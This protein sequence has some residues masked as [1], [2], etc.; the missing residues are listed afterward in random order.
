VRNWRKVVNDY[1]KS[2]SIQGSG[3][4]PVF[5]LLW[6]SIITDYTYSGVAQQVAQWVV[7]Q[8]ARRVAQQVAQQVLRW[9]TQAI[10]R[11]AQWLGRVGLFFKLVYYANIYITIT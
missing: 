6:A 7:Q 4:R 10:V 1:I 2:T 8:I 11:A 5:I 9:V 3:N